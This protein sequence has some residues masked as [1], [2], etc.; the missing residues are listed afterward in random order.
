MKK[1]RIIIDIIRSFSGEYIT[2]SLAGITFLMVLNLAQYVFTQ[3][4]P[5][6]TELY[7]AINIGF[8]TIKFYFVSITFSIFDDLYQALK[9]KKMVS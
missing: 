2:A 8:W 3:Q 6:S 1:I 5:M 7:R 9:T 4:E